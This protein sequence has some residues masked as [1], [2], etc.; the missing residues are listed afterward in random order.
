MII[1][2]TFQAFVH[3]ADAYITEL[4]TLTIGHYEGGI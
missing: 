4:F 2:L 1:Y 3:L